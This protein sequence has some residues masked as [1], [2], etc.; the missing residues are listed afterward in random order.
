MAI[1]IQGQLFA[2]QT[3]PFHVQLELAK[4][5]DMSIQSDEVR[6]QGRVVRV[7]RTDGRLARGDQVAFRLWVC[8]EGREP[9]GPA[10]IYYD[11][12]VRMAYVEAYLDGDPPECRLAA[13]EFRPISTPTEEP[14]L[15]A[16][17]LEKL[18]GPEG[19]IGASTSGTPTVKRWW[20]FWK[21]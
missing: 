11:D 12:F 9:T 13:Y 3:A 18:L 5:Q 8:L 20:Q 15:T 17:D 7:F 21:S 16:D 19:G 10:Y 6:V 1:P 4:S 14:M 2:R